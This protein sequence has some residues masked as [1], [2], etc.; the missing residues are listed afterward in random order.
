MFDIYVD[1]KGAIWFATDGGGVSVLHDTTATSVRSIN[2]PAQSAQLFSLFQNY[3]NPFNSNTCIKYSLNVSEKIELAIY[4]LLGREVKTL[5][6]KHQSSGEYEITWD[7]TDDSGKEVS[8][9]IYLAVL[10]SS[11]FGQFIK[12]SLI[13]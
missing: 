2:R 10:K 5:V 3:P 9:G 6:K 1:R 12:I 13:R 8:S 4:N 7:G 11:D